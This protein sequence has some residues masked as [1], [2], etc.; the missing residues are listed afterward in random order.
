MTNEHCK[1]YLKAFRKAVGAKK[2]EKINKRYKSI[3]GW[4]AP[5]DRYYTGHCGHCAEVK[6]LSRIYGNQEIDI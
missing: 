3:F 5:D 2:D 1:E 6:Y 4:L